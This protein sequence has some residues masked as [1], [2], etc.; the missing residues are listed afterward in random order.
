MEYQAKCRVCGHMNTELLLD[1]SHGYF[2]C[3]KCRTV[4]RVVM[5]R[6][7]AAAAEERRERRRALRRREGERRACTR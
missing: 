5:R 3:E 6:C 4:N 1:D 7:A 2:E